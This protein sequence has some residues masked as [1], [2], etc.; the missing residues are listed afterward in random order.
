MQM[1]TPAQLEFEPIKAKGVTFDVMAEMDF[2]D[3][4]LIS[5]KVRVSDPFLYTTVFTSGS[6]LQILSKE[7]LSAS[8]EID[9]AYDQYWEKKSALKRKKA[10][11]NKAK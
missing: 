5:M 2:C 9:K 7:L 10:K 8:K 4:P 3:E 6:G 1:N 11:P